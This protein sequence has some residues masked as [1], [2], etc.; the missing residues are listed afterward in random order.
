MQELARRR[1]FGPAAPIPAAA[2]PPRAEGAVLAEAQ[3]LWKQRKDGGRTVYLQLLIDTSG[4]MNDHQRLSQLKKALT[5]AS[6][7][8][9]SGNQVGLISFSDHPVRHLPL[10]PID[11]AGRRRLVATVNSLEANG[12]TSLY[13]GLAVALADLMRARQRD[14]NGRFHLLL[15]S[16]GERTSGLDFDDLRE[17]IRHSGVTIT[18]IAYGEVNQGELKAIATLRESVVYQGT[19][20]R[21][22]PLLTDLFQTNL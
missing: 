4:S 10:Q 13:D 9:N 11:A 21:I 22:V 1:D 3:R 8:I 20:Q 2:R 14:P 12:A 15:L 7:A 19:P 6:G 5:L 18:P 16:D 17:V